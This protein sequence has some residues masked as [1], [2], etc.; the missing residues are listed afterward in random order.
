MV[1]LSCTFWGDLLCS[2][3]ELIQLARVGFYCMQLKNPD[4][5]RV[6]DTWHTPLQVLGTWYQFLLYYYKIESTYL[7]SLWSAD[8]ELM[9]G[10]YGEIEFSSVKEKNNFSNQNWK[11]ACNLPSQ[12]MNSPCLKGFK[13]RRKLG[14]LWNNS[15]IGREV[16]LANLCTPPSSK[17][18]SLSNCTWPRDACLV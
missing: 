14:M 3:R 5:Y 10:S 13:Q 4:Y 7:V 16:E 17:I 18:L 12:L 1:F 2:K 6:Q 8:L 15:R 11:Q 9:G